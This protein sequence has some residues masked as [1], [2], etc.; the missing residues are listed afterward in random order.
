MP[1]R[2]LVVRHAD[3]TWNAEHRWAGHSD[4][5]LSE[6][7]MEQA[8]ALGA[9]HAGSAIDRVIASDLGRALATADA[10]R[11][12]CGVP[13]VVVDARWR[14]RSF[15]PW[16]GQVSADIELAWPGMLSEWRVGR[17]REIAGGEP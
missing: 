7:G 12:A 1:G 9:A 2:L 10:V 13:E 15:G 5:P 3:T 17:L 4:P 16:E 11:V 8:A 14:E 6:L